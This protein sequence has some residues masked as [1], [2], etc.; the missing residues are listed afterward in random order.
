M[1]GEGYHAIATSD[2]LQ[3]G[4]N[5]AVLYLNKEEGMY[6]IEVDS[7]RRDLAVTYGPFLKEELEVIDHVVSDALA[8]R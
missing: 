5:K 4:H 2:G 6:M 8:L 7:P 1:V 3:F